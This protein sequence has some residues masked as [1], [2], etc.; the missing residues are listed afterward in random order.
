MMQLLQPSEHNYEDERAASEEASESDRKIIALA[1][2]SVVQIHQ[3][4]A[5][6]NS[7]DDG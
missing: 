6:D 7:R 1:V 2:G 5:T 3:C 4:D